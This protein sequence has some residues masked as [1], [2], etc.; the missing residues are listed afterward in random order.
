MSQIRHR[1]W[2]KL[3]ERMKDR[4][5]LFAGTSPSVSNWIGAPTGFRKGGVSYHFYGT[6]HDARA[7]L[8]IARRKAA[9]SMQVYDELRLRRKRIDDDFGGQLSW[10]SLKDTKACRICAR[11]GNG[12]YLDDEERWPD[13]QDRLIDA[14][15]R[16]EKALRPHIANLSV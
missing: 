14:M 15:I 1:F 12:G 16:L 5:N 8:Y 13:I 10:E 7:E 2:N 4:T 3:L 11:V 9:E 6:K